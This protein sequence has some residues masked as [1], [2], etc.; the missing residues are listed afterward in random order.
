MK[1]K[2]FAFQDL[3]D[4]NLKLVNLQNGRLWAL[5]QNEVIARADLADAGGEEPPPI[6][7]SGIIERKN[8]KKMCV[9]KE[10]Q[11]CV[12]LADHELFYCNWGDNQLHKIKTS[13]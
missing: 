8:I 1:F 10:G 11:H 5:T 13:A 6:E 12:L 4:K 9:D 7:D 2:H 3:T